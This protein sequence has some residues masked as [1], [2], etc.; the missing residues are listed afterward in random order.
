MRQWVIGCCKSEQ[1]KGRNNQSIVKGTHCVR[2]LQKMCSSP[3]ICISLETLWTSSWERPSVSTTST[4]GTALLIPPSAVKMVSFTCFMAFPLSRRQIGGSLVQKK[5][6]Q[7]NY[8][9]QPLL[10]KEMQR[11]MNFKGPKV[12]SKQ[13]GDKKLLSFHSTYSV[14]Q[15]I[16]KRLW[17]I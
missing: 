15:I 14:I 10:K 5:N 16:S 9:S 1:K 12:E 17:G 4:L 11:N 7:Q 3:S 2:R 8:N 13:M 6:P